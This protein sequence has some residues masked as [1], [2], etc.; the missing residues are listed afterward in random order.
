VARLLIILPGLFFDPTLVQVREKYR[1]LS[2]RYCG[3]VL[4]V[5]SERERR[6][7]RYGNFTIHGLYLPD[8]ISSHALVRNVL[9]AAFVMTNALTLHRTVGKADV[10]IARDAFS[11]G[12]LALLVRGLTG[13]RLIIE[14][15]GNNAKAYDVNARRVR[16]PERLKRAIA[17]KVA[18]LV[19]MR[20]DAVKLLYPEQVG[21]SE[22]GGRSGRY[23][24]FHDF[25][26]ISLFREGRADTPHVLL[27]GGPWYLK[28]ADVLIKAF[29]R[30][31]RRFP[32]YRLKVVGYTPDREYFEALAA[33]DP[34]VELH[35]PVRY[36][37]V[38]K[39][40]AECAVFV[41]PSRTEAMGCVL[42]EAMACRK[43]IIASRVD[44]IPTYVKDGFNGLL[45]EPGSVD[46]LA[47]KLQIVL[48]N[49]AYAR[50]LADNAYRYVHEELS[51]HVYLDRFSTLVERAV[52][53]R[54]S[55]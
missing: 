9:Y 54:R 44:G 18:P 25:V 12:V 53:A 21:V 26:P 38:L 47:A 2:E 55:S 17:F 20:A 27:L 23:Q 28:G 51:E 11:S 1:L 4:C 13:S 19:L 6:V 40:M 32:N 16:F 41:L 22:L 34:S 8:C 36:E 45:V 29:Q 33:G 15:L 3:A 49:E 35:G 7:V 31:S 5:V 14:L 10:V 37:E 50:K 46:D 42:L 48:E 43:P 30:V 52:S 24:C 39:L